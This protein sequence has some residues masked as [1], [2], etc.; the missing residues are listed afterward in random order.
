VKTETLII[1]TTETEIEN[2]EKSERFFKFMVWDVD[3]ETNNRSVRD[4]IHFQ[5]IDHLF[6]FI[7]NNSKEFPKNYNFKL[8]IDDKF[9]IGD[10]RTIFNR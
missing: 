5:S 3:E 10:L 7:E 9:T 8:N 6:D 4:I 1:Y 2:L